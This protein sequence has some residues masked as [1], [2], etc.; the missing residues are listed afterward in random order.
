VSAPSEDRRTGSGRRDDDKTALELAKLA[1]EA[2]ARLSAFDDSK[3]AVLDALSSS[4]LAVEGLAT[5]VEKLASK[6]E[7]DDVKTRQ[8]RRSY[9]FAVVLVLVVLV[10]AGLGVVVVGNQETNRLLV[11]C[12]TPGPLRR[13]PAQPATGHP[14]FD[15]GQAQQEKAIAAILDGIDRRID[16]ALDRAGIPPAPSTTTTTEVPG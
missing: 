11:D 1:A 12:T 16:A 14:C 13:T 6:E 5:A 2:G 10:V 7:L 3:Q 9:L 15:R 4:R 8:D